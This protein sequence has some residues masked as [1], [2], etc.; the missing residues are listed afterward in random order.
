MA[1][2]ALI[3]AHDNPFN[4]YVLEEDGLYFSTAADVAPHLQQVRKQEETYQA[5]IEEKR[6]K[7]QEIY[8]WERIVDQYAAHFGVIEKMSRV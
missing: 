8:T 7:I 6:R 3:C 1:S 5:F 2:N 4:K